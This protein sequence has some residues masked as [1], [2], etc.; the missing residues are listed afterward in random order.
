[1]ATVY[2]VCAL[3]WLWEGGIL[4]FYQDQVKGKE[5]EDGKS[6]VK[7]PGLHP[8]ATSHPPR[9]LSRRLTNAFPFNQA[10]DITASIY[11]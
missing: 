11:F 10:L 5:T 2:R 9:T 8:P 4:V 7:I 3:T 1:M 6:R